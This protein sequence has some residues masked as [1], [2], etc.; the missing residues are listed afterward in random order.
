MSAQAWRMGQSGENS[1][2]FLLTS[3]CCVMTFPMMSPTELY[4]GWVSERCDL[5]HH[6][7]IQFLIWIAKTNANMWEFSHL[8]CRWKPNDQY[9]ERKSSMTLLDARQALDVWLWLCVCLHLL[10]WRKSYTIWGVGLNFDLFSQMTLGKVLL[11]W[12]KKL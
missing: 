5:K 6:W 7:P 12:K 3:E 1:I 10:E 11:K 4:H 2:S 9:T 8:C